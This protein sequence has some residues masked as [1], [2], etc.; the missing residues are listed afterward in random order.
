MSQKSTQLTIRKNLRAGE[1]DAEADEALMQQCFMDKGDLNLL[2]S[3]ESPKAVVV[4][5]TGTGKT[6][7]LLRIAHRV[8]HSVLLDP[9]DIS[10]RF[11]ENSNIIQF[12]EELG[13][14]LDLFYRLL[15]RNILTVELVKLK[16]DLKSERDTRSFLDSLKTWIGRDQ[17][18]K[19]AFEYFSEWGDRFWVNTDEHLKE[20]TKNF[21]VI[22]KRG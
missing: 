1:L 21:R 18:K 12:L 6:A 4:G 3:V 5:R 16:Y 7:L 14:K 8:E 13:I 20:L 19:Q 9:N 22:S 15:W 2:K 11:L 10:I 17:A